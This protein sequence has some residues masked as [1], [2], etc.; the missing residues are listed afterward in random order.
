MY[1]N[2]LVPLDGSQR[3]ESVIPYVENLARHEQAKVIFC[4]AIEPATRSA[5][6]DLDEEQVT[7]KPQKTTQMKEYL[8][9]WQEK[10]QAQGLTAEILLLR[11]VAVDAILEA[12]ELVKADLVAMTSQGKT[13][14]AKMLYGSVVSG[15]FNRL[16]RPFLMVRGGTKMTVTPH[17][18]ILV[19]LDGF[20]QSE[21]IIPYAK[22]IAQRYNTKLLLA[23]VVRTSHKATTLVDVN[24][25]FYE[26]KV[27]DTLFY[28][29]SQHQEIERL[30][31]AKDYLLKWQNKLQQEDV[32]VEVDLMYGRPLDSLIRL[33]NKKEVNMVAMTSHGQ[34]GLER[35]FYGSLT[36]ALM[37]H[38]S[39]PF[40]FVRS[41]EQTKEPVRN[42]I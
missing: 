26:P 25:N 13:G 1:H 6:V 21:K 20:K 32:K 8:Q 31:K 23:R 34:G 14:L 27:S 10:F 24:Q 7:F 30:Q 28:K 2:I 19:P 33:A 17:Q 42:I 38:L 3:A 11:G 40:L 37:Q 12:A 15:V 4:Q 35:V 5:V 16:H 41:S 22:E 9:G 36:T 18:Q 29:L 39:C